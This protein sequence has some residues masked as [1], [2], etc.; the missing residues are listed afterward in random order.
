MWNYVLIDNLRWIPMP[1]VDPPELTYLETQINCKSKI[2]YNIQI[3][4]GKKV[5]TDHI[6][7]IYNIT[8]FFI[9]SGF[10]PRDRASDI[11]FSTAITK[12]LS[13]HES[14]KV[15]QFW[16]PPIIQ[17]KRSANNHNNK[18]F[19]PKSNCQWNQNS[20]RP[21]PILCDGRSQSVG[22]MA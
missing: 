2:P 12:F 8:N 3:N 16:N 9:S 13:R 10:L 18:V 7:Q 15:K 11:P 22:H 4:R 19:T 21:S 6:I 1:H 20:D 17:P 5:T 14:P